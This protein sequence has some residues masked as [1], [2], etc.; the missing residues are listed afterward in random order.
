[1]PL[2][3]GK[4]DHACTEARLATGGGVLLI[5]IDGYHGTGFS[6]QLSLEDTLKVPEILRSVANNIEK[7]WKEKAAI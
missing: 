2:G 6:A 7:N 1:M 4:Y 3:P 5:V